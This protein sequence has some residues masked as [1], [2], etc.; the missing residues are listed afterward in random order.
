[1]KSVQE[2]LAE[3]MAM[4]IAQDEIAKAANVHQSSISRIARG[5][6]SPDYEVGKLIESFY[7]EKTACHFSVSA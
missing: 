1:M 7:S 4:G 3:L 5:K 6:Q 2:M